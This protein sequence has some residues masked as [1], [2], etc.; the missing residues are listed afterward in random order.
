M[1]NGHMEIPCEQ[2]DTHAGNITFPQLRWQ[3]VITMF[4]TIYSTEKSIVVFLVGTCG[5]GR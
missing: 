2:T 5:D 1:G 3:A 4:R